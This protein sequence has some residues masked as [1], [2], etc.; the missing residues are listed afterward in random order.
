MTPPSVIPSIPLRPEAAA[1]IVAV[2]AGC[3]SFGATEAPTADAS[4]PNDA[5]G[6]GGADAGDAAA[7][8]L[9][10]PQD[11][12]DRGTTLLEEPFN[13][14][15]PAGWN[16][17]DTANLVSLDKDAEDVVSAPSAF[18]AGVTAQSSAGMV[19]VIQRVF[20][21]SLAGTI[22]VTFQGRLY[23]GAQGFG[24]TD[25]DY[26]AIFGAEVRPNDADPAKESIGV[27]VDASGLRLH[28]QDSTQ[29]AVTPSGI[30]YGDDVTYQRWTLVIGRAAR[31]VAFWIGPNRID[32][33]LDLPFDPGL[34]AF[35]FGVAAS[36]K[37]PEV[38]FHMDDLRIALVP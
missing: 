5:A 8:S 1:L 9:P 19:G 28:V 33:P 11:C 29:D 16:K 26:V 7:P 36:G 12:V 31:Q 20:Q 23:V 27:S 15:P 10:S 21:R 38:I 37:V 22:C 35:T 2:L 4:V 14:V 18:R 34:A 30:A 6:G 3:G 13:A 25:K 24:T 32:L 17:T